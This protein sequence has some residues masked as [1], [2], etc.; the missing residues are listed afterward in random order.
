[1][2]AYNAEKYI[3]EAIHSIIQQ[4]YTSWE[5]IVVDDGS[6]DKTASII[7]DLAVNDKRIIYIY[8]ENGSQGK[9][10]NNGISHARGE[11]IAFLDADDCWVPE[12]LN[13]QVD[14]MR[15]NKI[16]LTFSDAYVFEDK[17]LFG[18][19]LDVTA[20]YYKGEEAVHQFLFC[21]YIP[22]LTVLVSKTAI[23][24]VNGFSEKNDIQNAEDYHLWIRMLINGA[25]FLGIDS[26]LA[27]YR[28]HQSSATSIQA[29]LLFPVI[30]CLKDISEE[31]PK[32]SGVISQSM[33]RLINDHLSKVNIS[34]WEMAER[35]LQARNSILRKPVAVSVWKRVYSIFGKNIFRKLFYIKMKLNPGAANKKKERFHPPVYCLG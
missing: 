34:K 26:S 5:L 21:N 13:L 16:D 4:T 23:D 7:K 25:S 31:W 33:Y 15:K 35:L 32:Y 6:V 29:N 20:G 14:I 9:A 10:R 24:K 3:A 18:K 8:Q 12:K 17:P 2:P 28:I 11:Y 27:H 1:M 22:I 19:K 30:N